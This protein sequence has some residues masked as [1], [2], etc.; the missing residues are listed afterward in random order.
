[1]VTGVADP[2]D[3]RVRTGF[4]RFGSQRARLGLDDERL[5]VTSIDPE[6]GQPNALIVSAVLERITA[7]ASGSVIT[8]E[9]EGNP[10]RL[11]FGGRGWAKRITDWR[12]VLE[13][14]GLPVPYRSM[15]PL[16]AVLLGVGIWVLSLLPLAYLLTLAQWVII[17]VVGLFVDLPT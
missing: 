7:H 13:F 6:T 14:S 8:F 1:M 10:Y 2:T 15:H 3:V 4:W 9:I 11:D 16:K 17:S 5:K 12:A